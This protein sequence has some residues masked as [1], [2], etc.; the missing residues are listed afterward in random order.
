[1]QIDVLLM[2]PG[3]AVS[4]H[5]DESPL[6]LVEPLPE[7]IKTQGPFPPESSLPQA[8]RPELNLGDWEGGSMRH[9]SFPDTKF[10]D[11]ALSI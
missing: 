1:M 6:F 10:C 3:C 7:E 11:I 8:Q 9:E 2:F 5:S 4:I